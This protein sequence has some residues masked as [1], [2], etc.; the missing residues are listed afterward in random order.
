MTNL[1]LNIIN[2]SDFTADN[3]P[4]MQ[5]I[6][7][8][9]EAALKPNLNWELAIVWVT[10]EESRQFNKRFR[11]KDYPTNVLSFPAD[12]FG[13]LLEIPM[14]GDLIICPT[15]ALQE[16]NAQNKEFH[17]HLAHL[18]IHGCL[19]LLGFDHETNQN[20]QI[21]ENLEIK[22]MQELNFA[23]PYTYQNFELL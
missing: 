1:T 12:D 3:L 23:N 4:N 21:M 16:A 22:I 10:A 15:V 13:D 19:H 14:L 9:A 7:C 8:W 11:D 5:Q 2:N 18:I 20:A 6:T 17:N